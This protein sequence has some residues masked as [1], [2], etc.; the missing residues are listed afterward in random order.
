MQPDIFARE[1]YLYISP[2]G[3]WILFCFWLRPFSRAEPPGSI[4]VACKKQALCDG[5]RTK[6]FSLRMIIL[7]ETRN[8]SLAKKSL[9]IFCARQFLVKSSRIL[10]DACWAC[11]ENKNTCR[12]HFTVIFLRS[13]STST[14]LPATTITPATG[15]HPATARRRQPWALTRPCRCSSHYLARS[16]RG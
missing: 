2:Y 11:H 5:P 15:H 1:A 6:S 12:V 8:K 3:A 14:Y 10:F 13:T 7:P 9:F 16:A 4:L